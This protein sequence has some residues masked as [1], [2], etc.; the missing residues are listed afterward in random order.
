MSEFFSWLFTTD[1][2]Q[3]FSILTLCFCIVMS[4]RAIDRHNRQ[5][6][7][8]QREVREL[9]RRCNEFAHSHNSPEE[10]GASRRTE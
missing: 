2:L 8:L 5:I 3:D 6:S 4:G 7:K 1:H 10:R 9:T